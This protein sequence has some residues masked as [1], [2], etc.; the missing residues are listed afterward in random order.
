MAIRKN[1]LLFENDYFDGIENT[2][3]KE[4]L[5]LVETSI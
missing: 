3:D 4:S 5:M 1:Y 2:S